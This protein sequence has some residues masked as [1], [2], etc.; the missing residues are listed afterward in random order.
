ME[1]LTQTSIVPIQEPSQIGVAR[2]IATDLARAAGIEEQ[3]ASAL[4]VVVVELANNLLQH[5]GGGQLHIHYIAPIGALEVVAVDHGRGMANVDRCLTDGFSTAS[6][7]GLGLGAVRRF[8]TRFGAYSLPDRCTVVA[9]RMS[10]RK[11]F[12]DL[13]VICTA[14]D[15][16]ALSGD[17]WSV[18]DDGSTFVVVDGLGHG[19]FAADAAKVAIEVFGKSQ[20]LPPSV[21]LERMH[22]V[23]R[24]TRGAAGAVAKIDRTQ[25]RIHFAGIGNISSV[26]MSNGRTQ[27]MVSHNGTLG[28]QVRRVQ[29]FEYS[30]TPG[31]LLL[32]QSDGLS[33]QSRRGLPASLLSE[34]PMVIAPF[35]FAEQ[36]RGRDDATL[37]VNRLA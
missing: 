28:H 4:N 34:S 15:G 27:N 35:I 20:S 16:E 1:P 5:A 9:A 33:T 36:L 18:S 2:R 23:M 32:M 22:A 7:P 6:T 11:S 25:R 37:L 3:R 14:L 29:Q 10:E 26:L 17:A 24:S 30:Y 12:P 21:I 13:S 8:A 31:D 19:I